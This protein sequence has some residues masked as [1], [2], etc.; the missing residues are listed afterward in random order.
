MEISNCNKEVYNA[1]AAISEV[2]Y[3]LV[4]NNCNYSETLAKQMSDTF[5]EI[6]KCIPKKEAK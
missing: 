5:K 3:M 1:L 6:N 2:L 4:S